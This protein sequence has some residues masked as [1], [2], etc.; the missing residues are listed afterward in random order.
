M[1]GEDSGGVRI[2]GFRPRGLIPEA[3]LFMAL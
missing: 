1:G 2:V 3:L